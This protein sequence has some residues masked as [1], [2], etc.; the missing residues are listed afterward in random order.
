MFIGS[1]YVYREWGMFI[2]SGV[3]LQGAGCG[4]VVTTPAI[5]I[6]INTNR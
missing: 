1:G 4:L 3:C 6:T 5:T 2:G